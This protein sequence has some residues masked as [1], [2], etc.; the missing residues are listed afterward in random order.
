MVADRRPS[1][2]VWTFVSAARENVEGRHGDETPAAQAN[3]RQ[4]AEGHQ[5]VGEGS[6]DVQQC[7]FGS[8]VDE[9][10]PA[11]VAAPI[12]VSMMA[13]DSI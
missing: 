10:C 7:S 9:A 6:R 2:A 8:G 11:A 12:V 1:Q 5:L 4:L 3:D 13:L